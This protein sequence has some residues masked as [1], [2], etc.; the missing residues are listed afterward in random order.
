MIVAPTPLPCRQYL[1]VQVQYGNKFPEDPVNIIPSGKHVSKWPAVRNTCAP[2]A[3]LPACQATKPS[4]TKPCELS[5]GMHSVFRHFRLAGLDWV[6]QTRQAPV[7]LPPFV[8]LWTPT[9]ML[10]PRAHSC[11]R[12]P[13]GTSSAGGRSSLSASRPSISTNKTSC[14]QVVSPLQCLVGPGQEGTVQPTGSQGGRGCRPL[15]PQIHC[16]CPLP[17]TCHDAGSSYSVPGDPWP[18]HPEDPNT[19]PFVS[20]LWQVGSQA[21]AFQPHGMCIDWVCVACVCKTPTVRCRHSPLQNG[22][23]V[24]IEIDRL[25]TYYLIQA[26]FPIYINT[27]LALLVR[28][29]VTA[30]AQLLRSSSWCLLAADRLIG[31]VECDSE[32]CTACC[33]GLLCEPA[34]PGHAPRHRRHPLPVSAGASW[35]TGWPGQS[36]YSIIGRF[37]NNQRTA[38]L[39]AAGA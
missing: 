15:A 38:A 1:S 24:F 37:Q 5:P 22:F 32:L 39:P 4:T 13:A 6:K 29:P 23:D 33:A 19:I 28:Q 3:C 8:C 16:S 34:P 31:A 35:L 7:A 20:A 18:L 27:C 30:A 25:S 17:P 12:L 36:R 10:Q 26:V 21:A 14:R 2:P 9:R 11:T